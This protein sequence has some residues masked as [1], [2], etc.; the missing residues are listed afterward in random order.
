MNN[1]KP[2][3]N[4]TLSVAQA[5]DSILDKLDALTVDQICA[6]N[7]KAAARWGESARKS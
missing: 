1:T 7:D 2:E 4:G 5:V 3:A 6:L